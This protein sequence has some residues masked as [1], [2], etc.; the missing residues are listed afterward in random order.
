MIKPSVELDS[1]ARSKEPNFVLDLRN[2]HMGHSFEVLVEAYRLSEPDA[3][4]IL[5]LQVYDLF[6][7]WQGIRLAAPP[8]HPRPPSSH[9]V[10]IE[11]VWQGGRGMSAESKRQ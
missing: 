4:P 8:N 2:G 3:P 11:A 6:L 9:S 10:G 5:L 1:F 7:L